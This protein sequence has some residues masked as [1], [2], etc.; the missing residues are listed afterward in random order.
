M[1]K[2]FENTMTEADFKRPLLDANE[3]RLARELQG[4]ADFRVDSLNGSLLGRLLNF[5]SAKR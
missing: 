2:N 3:E 5:L 1:P 4:D